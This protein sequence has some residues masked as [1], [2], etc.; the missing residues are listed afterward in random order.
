MLINSG[1]FTVNFN[2]NS[3]DLF[4]L[5]SHNFSHSPAQHNCGIFLIMRCAF[6]WPVDRSLCPASSVIVWQW[7]G[8]GSTQRQA[9]KLILGERLNTMTRLLSFKRTQS[10]VVIG[11]LTRHNTLIRHLHLMRL[12]ISPFGRCGAEDENS[13]HIL[14][15]CEALASLRHTYPGSFF[16]D[17]KY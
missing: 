6:L 12:T 9:W 8:L 17:P 3:S 10:K 7:C 5:L 16:L 4:A 15:E 1:I 11:L 13:T 2:T 14:C